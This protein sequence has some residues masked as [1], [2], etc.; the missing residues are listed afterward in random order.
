DFALR[1]PELEHLREWAEKLGARLGRDRKLSDVY[2]SRAS[3]LR[4]QQVIDVD[5]QKAASL[6]VAIQDVVNTLQ[7]LR[8]VQPVGEFNRFGRTW[9]RGANAEPASGEW[10][11]TV[12]NL[13]VR[14]RQG[15]MVPL[16]AIASVRQI[17][18]PWALDFLDGLPMLEIT[19][20]RGADVTVEEAR[21]LSASL[22]E[23]VR[24]ELRLSAEYRLT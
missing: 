4:P 22:A 2:V 5:R 10:M 3:T 9:A 11:K 21:K 6:G 19:A 16:G 14:N 18:A 12:R 1:G 20:N 17:A 8:G 24:K 13:R 7:V 15:E 23:E